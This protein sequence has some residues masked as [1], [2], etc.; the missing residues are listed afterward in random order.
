MHK[1]EL[2]RGELQLVRWAL[3]VAG[4]TLALDA[5]HPP[6]ERLELIA[7]LEHVDAVIMN[8]IEKDP[9]DNRQ[10]QLFNIENF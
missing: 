10:L 3:Q 5:I 6:E 7:V 2:S 1:I 9:I 4:D 8:Q